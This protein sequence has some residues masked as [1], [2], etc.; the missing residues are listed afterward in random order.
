MKKRVQEG[1]LREVISN[2]KRHLFKKYI[3]AFASI[4]LLFFLLIF[5]NSSVYARPLTCADNPISLWHFNENTGSNTYDSCGGNNGLINEAG[6]ISGKYSYALNYDGINDFVSFGSSVP[7]PTSISF[8]FDYDTFTGTETLVQYGEDTNPLHKSFSVYWVTAGGNGLVLFTRTSTSDYRT[9]RIANE[10]QLNSSYNHLIVVWEGMTKSVYLN[11]VKMNLSIYASAGSDTNSN[12]LSLS[13]NLIIGAGMYGTGWYYYDGAEDEVATFNRSL[14]QADATSFYQELPCFP[15][16]IVNYTSCGINLNV[17]CGTYDNK[18]KIYYDTNSCGSTLNLP[19]DNGTCVACNY[20]D[21]SWSEIPSNCTP[22][23]KKFKIYNDTNNCCHTTHLPSDCNTVPV[24]NGT[25]VDCNYCIPSWYCGKFNL[26]CPNQYANDNL[27]CLLVNSSNYATCCAVTNLTSDCNFTGNLSL[28]DKKCGF[29]YFNLN[30]SFFM[31]MW[32]YIQ[33]VLT[34]PQYPYV[35]CNTSYPISVSLYLNGSKINITRLWINFTNEPVGNQTF[36]FT[37]N[38]ITKDYEATFIFPAEDR[39]FPFVISGQD[40][41]QIIYNTTGTFLVRCP[42]YVTIEGYKEKNTSA[43]VNK[44]AVVTAEF[45]EERNKMI[46]KGVKGYNDAL[47]NFIVPLTF[48]TQFQTP[49]FHASYIGGKAV[50]KLYEKDRNYGIRLF[51]G[52]IDFKQ[53]VYSPP[54]MT[55]GYGVN[56]FLGT[57]YLNGS[58]TTYQYYL[59]DK[60]IHQYRWLFNWIVILALIIVMVVSF[61]LMMYVPQ[62]AMPFG[63]GFTFMILVLRILAW[64]LLGQ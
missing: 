35:D 10:S 32:D 54:N 16:W 26:P 37:W 58:D 43:Y 60:D 47:E 42:F 25:F 29:R 48:R 46:V 15:N 57:L 50:L 38:A 14:T 6:W 59:E 24:D 44:F 9:Y 2:Y 30:M 27:I 5:S 19:A 49:V 18:T 33:P 62:I 64:F 39:D 52:I 40:P 45:P 20:C 61:V 36:N 55:K 34:V 41:N 7:K 1:F 17:S 21:S 56:M 8:W 22:I 23:D 3:L 28:Y 12:D 53:G 4:F 11:G 63:I 13:D 51:D 31:P